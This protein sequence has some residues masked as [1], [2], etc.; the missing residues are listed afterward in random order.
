MIGKWIKAA[1]DNWEENKQLLENENVEPTT[2]VSEPVIGFVNTVIKYPKRFKILNFKNL[3][4]CSNVYSLVLFDNYNKVSYDVTSTREG[5]YAK[6]ISFLTLDEMI[7]LQD[8]LLPYFKK[9]IDRRQATVHERKNRAER[10]KYM[11][12]Y[13]GE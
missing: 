3:S 6:N 13:G 10:R 11:N 4:S 12:L 8:N 9:Y 5:A 2:N 1:A 7:Y